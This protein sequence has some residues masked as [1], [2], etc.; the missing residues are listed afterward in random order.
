MIN[1][2]NYLFTS[3]NGITMGLTK[4]SE[5]LSIPILP[6]LSVPNPITWPFI[7]TYECVFPL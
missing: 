7:I 3:K 2:I 1:F 6:R 5:E 4:A